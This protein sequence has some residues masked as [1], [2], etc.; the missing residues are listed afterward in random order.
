MRALQRE[1][2]GLVVARDL[3]EAASGRGGLTEGSVAAV[4]FGATPV[5]HSV[6]VKERTNQAGP[7]QP[8][9][10]D[11]RSAQALQLL[12]EILTGVSPFARLFV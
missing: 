9:S 5:L 12:D 4:R 3:N 7:D 8:G 10:A 2:F 6:A 11:W 1:S